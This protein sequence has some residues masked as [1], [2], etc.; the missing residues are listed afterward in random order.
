MSGN[1]KRFHIALSFPGEHRG[2]VEQVAAVLAEKAGRDH[3]LYDQYYEAEFARPDLDTYLQGLYHDESELIAVF[4][5]AEY[6]RKEWCGLEW[7]AIRD[8]IKKRRSAEVMP[9]RFDDTEIPG[10]FSI[11]GCVWIADRSPR[12][13]A[14]LILERHG[15]IFPAADVP[16][17]GDGDDAPRVNVD[18]LPAGGRHFVAREDELR[19]LDDAWADDGVHAI[20]IVAWGGVG[21]SALV[22]RWLTAMEQDGWRGARRVYGWSFY[23]QGTEQ[24]L[25]S[26]D[27]FIDDALRWFGDDDPSAGSARDRGLRLAELAR[28]ERTLLVLDGVEPLQHAPGPLA[29]RL[30][31][32]ALAALVKSLARSNP[33]LLVISTREAVDDVANLEH[34]SAPR[35]ELGTLAGDDGAALLDKLGVRGTLAERRAT[36]ANY[37]GHA[38]ALSLL[39]GYLALACDGE[40][41]QLP[42]IDVGEAVAAQ[43]GHAWRVIAAYE[44]WLGEREVSVL[45]L[46]GLFD[47]PAEP[48]ALAVLRAGPVVASLNDG[49]VDIGERAWNVA[50][51]N[52][53]ACG[54]LTQVE[55]GGEALSGVRGPLPLDAHPLVRAYFGHQLEHHH[56][57]AWRAGQERLYEHYKNAAPE[58]PDTFEEMMPLWAAVVHGCRAGKHKQAFDEVYRPRIRRGNEQYQLHKLGAFGADLVAVGSFFVRPWQE[59]AAGLSEGDKAWLLNQA[60]FEL[61]GLGR[62]TEAV[63]PMEAAV[64]LA[65]TQGAWKNAAVGAGSV[66]ELSLTLG[67]VARA[68]TSGEESIE[69]ADKSGDDFQRMAMRATLADA[70]HHAGRREDAAAAF[71][72]AE[73]MQ[74]ECQPS[75]PRFYSLRGYQYCDLLLGRPG[76]GAWSALDGVAVEDG[77]AGRLRQACEEVRGRAEQLFEW[78]VP[79]DPILDIALDNLSLGRAHFGLTLCGQ[80][81]GEHGSAESAKVHLDRAVEGLRA[82]GAE[83]HLPRGLLA[84]AAFRRVHGDRRSAAADLDEAEEIAERGHMLPHLADAH[85]E[86]ALLHLATGE[87]ARARERLALAAE[88]VER[89]GYGR[90]RREVALLE[91]AS[92]PWP[93]LPPSP[94][95]H[96]GEGE[97]R[98]C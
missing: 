55:Q 27:A 94:H 82:S 39:G 78:R 42:E 25:T 83:H 79:G 16:A 71:R 12:T 34:A 11:D 10:L 72:Q 49:L 30:K 57:A 66:S 20:S 70:L 69:L 43:G 92:P 36:S 96:P 86:R 73:A 87:E 6:R 33:G 61:R 26:A 37:Q 68:V 51:S 64:E 1:R 24:R 53:R 91:G 8:L 76:P 95:T 75:Y 88:L 41:R 97:G 93:P 32:P 35:L 46:L 44:N 14:E 7:R 98:W 47:R 54:L 38:L 74:A 22:D 45:R 2:F 28:R 15:L 89:C 90:R 77:D 58:L 81:A 65:K 19:R 13:V 67:D 4:L 29:G 21:K 60:G 85:L 50:I 62:L 84:R 17:P 18:R 23:S 63:Q 31:D 5:C 56:P 3:V 59:V 9:F 80:G 48:E 40:I 52:L